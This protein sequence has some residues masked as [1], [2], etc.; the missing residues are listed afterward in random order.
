MIPQSF[1]FRL[2]I[3]VI[4][5]CI[6]P[7]ALSSV[8]VS[9]LI[10]SKARDNFI[11]LS[12]EYTD[13][14][15]IIINEGILG[16]AADDINMLSSD[17]RTLALADR[18]DNR[19]VTS[20]SE[21]P[22]DA[23]QHIDLFLKTHDDIL[24]VAIGTQQ[25]GYLKYPE[26]YSDTSF[27][28]RTRNWYEAAL[29]DQGHVQI[30]DPYVRLD[31]VVVV[32]IVKALTDGQQPLGVIVSGWSLKR[33]Q[34]E[35]EKVKIGTSGYVMVLN[36]HDRF[37]VCPQHQE[38]LLK[39]PQELGL[40]E[41]SNILQRN[42]ETVLTELDG[43]P[44]LLHV[45]STGKSGWKVISV[46]DEAELLANVRQVFNPLIPV[47]VATIIAILLGV[48]YMTSRI[49]Q[50]V[51]HL[52][53]GARLLAGGDLNVQVQVE[54]DDE[55]GILANSFNS[56]AKQIKE[57]FNK[58]QTQSDELRKREHEFKT[59]V[60]N[61]PDIIIRTD[62]DLNIVYIN[63]AITS[64]TGEA[65]G[66]YTAKSHLKLEFL[67][68][69]GKTLAD[70]WRAAFE[71]AHEQ[72]GEIEISTPDGHKL[73]FQIHIV[74]EFDDKGKV[75]TILSMV[76]DF[77]DQR[78]IE[79]QMAH[80]DRL[81]LVGEMA[82]GIAHEVRNPLTTVRGFLQLIRRNEACVGLQ[83]K[84][85]LMIDEIDRANF[86]ITEYLALAKNKTINPHYCD[87]NAI[88]ESLYPLMQADAILT[89]KSIR[90]ELGSV[91][92]TLLDEKEVRQL[93]LNLVRNSLES[94]SH[95]GM[96]TIRTYA[97]K[98]A[99]ILAVIDQGGGIPPEIIDQIGTPFVS[100]KNNGTGLGLPVCYS[101]AAR[102][103]AQIW[104]ESTP[105]GTTFFISF[106]LKKPAA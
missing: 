95:G 71:T 70:Y 46:I 61:V 56:M 44:Q 75:E 47:F 62:R 4:F 50:P 1:R 14:I 5:A 41:M 30:I 102:H 8:Y 100:T 21:I 68:C 79:K 43:R 29:S 35:V 97:E 77:T 17:S 86:I 9:H 84:F 89:S 66:Y 48:Y 59:L 16:P 42:G 26:F 18:L 2:L 87:I 85:Q 37:I 33:L 73:F 38:W 103:K 11:T 53:Q 13:K 57:N 63:P 10:S 39:T 92:S 6:I 76:R 82:A 83:D 20:R 74:P 51:R 81:N 23:Y 60:E 96:V 32:A 91:P 22:P 90:L 40:M 27:D 98:K 49:I 31:N 12:S 88:I 55:F 54:R 15:Q 45:N 34:Q 94:M 58:I 105:N 80:W 65:A 7:V 69:E 36:E 67:T 104:F 28:P 3:Y 19:I 106:P 93:I 78:H 64:Y 52:S 99:V 72:R 101:I 25:G 24:G